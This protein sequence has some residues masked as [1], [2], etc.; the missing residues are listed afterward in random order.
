[1]DAI[2]MLSKKILASVIFTHLVLGYAIPH[3]NAAKEH[4]VPRI[5]T[6][7]E[8]SFTAEQ[9]LLFPGSDQ[10]VDS[11]R[12]EYSSDGM[13]IIRG[14]AQQR[15]IFVQNFRSGQIWLVDQK[16]SLKHEVL[17]ESD[18]A[19]SGNRNSENRPE[20]QASGDQEATSENDTITLVSGLL[21][22]L[23]CMNHPRLKPLPETR[24]RGQ[25]VS[26]WGCL[27]HKAELVRVD[28]FSDHW[29]VVVRSELIDI[30]IEELHSI[31]ELNF[32]A[33]HFLVGDDYE[34]VGLMELI[35]GPDVPSRKY[36]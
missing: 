18:Q 28:Y 29:N 26:A 21:S 10:I 6:T 3:A 35:R 14:S 32:A 4:K 2:W 7:V 8:R 15:Q 1:M 17:F 9:V 25:R 16:R 34:P 27:D 31:T 22:N 23:P 12:V 13:R 24:W 11:S 30:Q 5:E 19:Q 33:G 36:E 20:T